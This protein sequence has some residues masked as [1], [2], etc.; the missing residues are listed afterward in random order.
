MKKI[1]IFS[2][3]FDPIHEGHIS[4]ARE[5]LNTFQMD[6]VFFLVEPR[7]RRKQGIKAFAHRVSMVRLAIKNEPQLGLII[8]KQARFSA[9]ET[10]PVLQARFAGAELC[11][12]MGEDMLGHLAD[13]PHVT[14]L[15]EA[16][17]F[18]IG[19]RRQTPSDI[20]KLLNNLEKTR[21]LKLSYDVFKAQDSNIS[22]STVRTKLRRGQE[23]LGLT[24]EVLD[25]IRRHNL[26]SV[27]GE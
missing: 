1:G 4:F 20:Q 26:Y 14:Q 7:P 27:S 2:G 16:V 23:P 11:M 18:I 12:L 17:H 9:E 6:K 8:L 3:T 24:S 10:L 25:Y 21:G 13:W 5:A 15:V 19:V 22:S